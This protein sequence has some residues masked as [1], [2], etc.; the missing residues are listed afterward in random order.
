MTMIPH[1]MN[2]KSCPIQLGELKSSNWLPALRLTHM[3]ESRS[4]SG[5]ET[6]WNGGEY[7]EFAGLA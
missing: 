3:G 6:E 5:G 2:T 7:D 1:G 4:I